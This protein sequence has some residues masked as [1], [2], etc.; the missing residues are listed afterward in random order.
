MNVLGLWE[1]T[2][3]PGKSPHR[4]TET[5][6]A[7]HS[8][9]SASSFEPRN[10]LPRNDSVNPCGPYFTLEFAQWEK[11]LLEVLQH[12]LETTAPL[13]PFCLQ[14]HIGKD[15]RHRC[16]HHRR[17]HL[18]PLSTFHLALGCSRLNISS[19]SCI[20]LTPSIILV[21]QNSTCFWESLFSSHTNILQMCFNFML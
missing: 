3:T 4:Q 10:F 21:L 2:G 8:K 15:I 5:I 18:F 20:N 7:L 1:E 14:L 16:R 19:S 11:Q 9:T 17:H 6:Q 12:N 13:K